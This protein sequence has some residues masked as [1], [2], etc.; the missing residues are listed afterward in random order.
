MALV[1]TAGGDTLAGERLLENLVQRTSAQASA[2]RA[3]TFLPTHRSRSG[4]GIYVARRKTDQRVLRFCC[5][6]KEA[7]KRISVITSLTA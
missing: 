5:R 6:R 2:S 1:G 7:I 3:T 4:S